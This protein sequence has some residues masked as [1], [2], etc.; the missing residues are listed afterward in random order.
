MKT[1]FRTVMI[2]TALALVLTG[3]GV[4]PASAGT[5][6]SGTVSVTVVA[7]G[8]TPIPDVSVVVGAIDDAGSPGAPGDFGR[9]DSAGV[10]TSAEL[11]PGRYEVSAALGGAFDTEAIQQIDI[12]ANVDS[13]E[14]VTL[15]KVQAITGTLTANGIGVT[16]GQVEAYSGSNAFSTE[17]ADGEYVLF[18]K[19]GL[20]YLVFAATD[21][22]QKTWVDTYFGDTVRAADARTVKVEA[23]RPTTANIAAYDKLG[24]LSGVVVNSSGNPAKKVLVTVSARDRHGYG[25][26]T[27]DSKGRYTIGGLPAGTYEVRASNSA[28]TAWASTAKK[29]AVGKTTKATLRL[30]KSTT[31]KG[32]ITL[33]LTAPRALVKK[34][35]ACATLISSEGIRRE[36]TPGYCLKPNGKSKKITFGSLPAG[37]YTLALNGANTSKKVTVKKNKTT[38]VSMTRAAGTVISG[39]IT[40]SA[41][42]PSAKSTVYI[43]DSKGTPLGSTATSSKGTYKISGALRGS[44]RVY[45]DAATSSQGATTWK[46]ATLAGK[47]RTINVKLAK[48]ATITGKVVNSRGEPVAGIDVSTSSHKG[49]SSASAIT[50]SAGRYSLKGLSAGTYTVLTYDYPTG[51]Y[52][53]GKASKKKVAAGKTVRAATITVK[54]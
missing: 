18:V 51:G 28:F 31:H 20:S 41:G 17:V 6:D 38:K 37:T 25:A 5:A 12:T 40:T 48:S 36:G 13:S 32:K 35:R 19:P 44:Y 16:G 50:D 7:P 43:V 4:A 23:G 54:G 42:K 26:A 47:K 1:S 10:F 3:V 24:A 14:T 11:A 27:T 45:A 15:T 21:Y 22:T 2:A 49:R 52:Y 30:K 9:T 39:K 34:G 33:T 29:I 8:G 53:N 46:S